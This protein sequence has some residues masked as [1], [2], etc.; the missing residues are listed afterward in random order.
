MR[1]LFCTR[2]AFGHLYPVLPLA[3]AARDLGH[4]VHV[5]S[6][7]DF[8][9]RIAALG[10]AAHRAGPTFA[11][12]FDAFRAGGFPNGLPTDA[13]GRPDPAAAGSL[14]V[15]I[16]G[17]PT[18]ADLVPLLAELTPDIVVFGDMD[19]GAPIRGR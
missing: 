6:A 4:D 16:I 11:E 1:I 2:P 9:E 7:G 19:R 10:L 5:T 18:A 8:V 17:R 15:D 14:F 13:V 12:A 3:I